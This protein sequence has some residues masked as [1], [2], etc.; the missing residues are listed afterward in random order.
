MSA[1]PHINCEQNITILPVSDVLIAADYYTQ[2]L[3]F[4]LGF[5]WGIRRILYA[6]IWTTYNY[7]LAKAYPIQIHTCEP[8]GEGVA[9]PQQQLPLKQYSADVL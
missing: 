5:T 9:S 4:R 8:F 3:G 1:V 2:K 6:L 7:S